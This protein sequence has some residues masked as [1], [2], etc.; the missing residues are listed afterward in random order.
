MRIISFSSSNKNSASARAS[1]VFPTPVGPRKINEPIGRFGS[2]KPGAAATHGIRHACQSVVL[3]HNAIAQTRSSIFTSFCASPSSKRPAGIPV[4][5]LTIFAMSSSSTSSFSIGASFCTL[6][7]VFLRLLQFAFGRGDAS[8]ANFRHFCQF[9]GALIALFFGFELLDLFLRACGFCRWHLFRPANAPC[10]RWNLRGA[11]PVLF[12]FAARRSFEC[13]SFSFSSAWRSISSCMMRRSISSISIGQR[14]DLH[15]QARRGFVDQVD[16]FVR[17]EAVGDVAMRKRRRGK[18]RRILNA[19]A[20]M[21]FV[22]FFQAA[23]NRDGV[24]DGGLARPA[25]AGSGVPARDLSRCIFCI[26]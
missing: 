21:H 13:A 18:D 25:R 3:A 22:A 15:A 7:K 17:Q 11:W 10:G 1:S 14:I 26:R 4:H 16:R 23:Q 24:F 2:D 9:A 20:V 19:H 6:R 12:R 8:V 5:L